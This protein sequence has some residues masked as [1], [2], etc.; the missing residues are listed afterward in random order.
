MEGGSPAVG[1]AG[2][3]ADAPTSSDPAPTASANDR[4]NTAD[5]QQPS[6]SSPLVNAA[7]PGAKNVALVEQTEP[8]TPTAST[9]NE[10]HRTTQP[11]PRQFSPA[12]R[13][14]HNQVKRLGPA[15]K[16]LECPICFDLFRAA[17]TTRCG[18]TFCFSCIMRHFRNHKSCPVCGGFLTRDQIA[19][20][21]SVQKAVRLAQAASPSLLTRSKTSSRVDDV[22][23][24]TLVSDEEKPQRKAQR[25]GTLDTQEE[26]VAESDGEFKSE[27]A[28]AFAALMSQQ[29]GHA[30][31][32]RQALFAAGSTHAPREQR[33]EIAPAASDDQHRASSRERPILSK[34][35][36]I[37]EQI[38][39]DLE[40]ETQKGQESNFVDKLK[41]LASRLSGSEIDQIVETLLEQR[42]RLQRMSLGTDYTILKSFLEY[43]IELKRREL[44]KIEAEL[45][46]LE[47]DLQRANELQQRRA[48]SMK[49]SGERG[50]SEAAEKRVQRMLILFEQLQQRYLEFRPPNLKE[51]SPQPAGMDRDNQQSHAT[52]ARPY[53]L[54]PS[55]LALSSVTAQSSG[56]LPADITEV[57]ADPL[58]QFAHELCT[59][60]KY[61][62]MRCLTLLRYGEPFR[63]SNIV[64][65]LDFDMFGELLAA[66]GVMRKIKIFDLH[67]V[68]DHDA[69]VK[70]PICELPARAKLSC[71]SWSPSTRQHI[72]SSDYDGVVCIWD[73]ESCKL[74]AEYEEHEKRAWTVDYCPMKPHILASGSDD[75]NVKIWSTTQRDSVGTIRMNANVCCIKF[76]PLQHECLLA[77]GSAD[78]Q[79]YV[80]DLRSM[81][82]PLHILKG[83]RK[84][85]SYIRFFCSNREIV[86][87]STDST[88]RL[89]DLRSCQCE[90]IY[91]GH[92]NERN[93]V[94]LSVKPDW[95]ACGSEDNHVYTY[96]R[97]L[98]SPAIV[99]DFAAEPAQHSAEV[100]ARSG[101]ALDVAGAPGSRFLQPDSG[102]FGGPHFVSAVAW[103]KDTDTLAA[104]NSQGLIRIFELS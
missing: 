63:G 44:A 19:P 80:Y 54:G 61:A 22:R 40:R 41:R 16:S 99:S 26:C 30:G 24:S 91:T 47:A 33:Q 103:R 92:C 6:T 9:G 68:V 31:R 96:Y 50:A 73:T 42:R 32:P 82:Q 1:R 45:L 75:G 90:R 20:D 52:R 53:D 25:T 64:S 17:V 95:I 46:Q 66:A 28:A 56:H 8:A 59:A 55:P 12:Q 72:A 86:T 15:L 35:D 38:L 43:N 13:C 48:E 94:G 4:S 69:Q 100:V 36:P 101:G 104:A 60:T 27:A 11:A 93:F 7:D 57:D 2:S 3:L 37:I 10:Q 87:A 67:T 70:Y 102:T 85:I 21:S 39:S 84:A 78:H 14:N 98:T 51:S 79:A 88:L 23:S 76:A 49:D 65:C 97:S 62:Q 74:V 81:A 18:H 5:P 71:L 89:W 29:S 34:Q 77:V 83:H 58:E